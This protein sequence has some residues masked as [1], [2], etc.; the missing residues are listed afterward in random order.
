MRMFILYAFDMAREIQITPRRINYAKEKENELFETLMDIAS[1]KQD[2]IKDIILESLSEIRESILEKATNY[3][4]R[5]LYFINYF[6]KI[7]IINIYYFASLI[8]SF[9]F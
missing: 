7:I 2:E 6:Y 9:I 5:G 3:E 8:H 1:K 4:F